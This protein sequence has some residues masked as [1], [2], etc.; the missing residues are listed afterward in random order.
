MKIKLT[1]EQFTLID[2]DDF[3]RVNNQGSWYAFPHQD[4]YYATRGDYSSGKRKNIFLH[5]FIM[6]CPEGKEV[7]HINGDKL[8]NRKSNLRICTRSENAKNRRISKNNTSGFKGVHWHKG[9][10]KWFAEICSNGKRIYGR[11]YNTK[12]EAFYRY[13]ELATQ[14]HGQFA[15]II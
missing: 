14:L 5:R 13:K 9:N 11:G 3:Q 8:D 2:E 12:E 15:K 6:N 1:R 7:D 10:K 4:S